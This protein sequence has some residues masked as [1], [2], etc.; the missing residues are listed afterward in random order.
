MA[1]EGDVGLAFGLVIGAGLCTTIGAVLAFFV[2]LNNL[3]LLAGSLGLS[4]GVMLY[5]SFT[6][7]FMAKGLDGFTD[8]GVEEGW[9]LRLATFSFFGGVAVIWVLDML[10]HAIVHCSSKR[11]G[12][13][14][15]CS[16]CNSSG[17][18]GNLRHIGSTKDSV[19]DI[20]EVAEASKKAEDIEA[21]CRNEGGC[22][23]KD[24]GCANKNTCCTDAT[25]CHVAH[26]NSS[27][28]VV[29][30]LISND[31]HSTDLQKMGMLTALAIFIHN[32]P[33][34]LAT[35]LAAL[36]SPV[37][38]IAIAFAIAIHNIPEGICVAMPVYY[39]T[40]SRLKGFLWAFFSGLSEPVGG[41]LGY[42]ILYGDNMSDLA[43]GILFT[44]VAGMMVYISIRELIPTALKYDPEDKY[45]TKFVFLGM[46]VMAVSLL[47]FTI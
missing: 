28:P 47:L 15:A 18:E 3:S 36:A 4:A 19:K 20:V 10:V 30:A 14:S 32:L 35:F 21:C 25:A 9:D 7:I 37:S 11:Q 17:E 5:V 31:H 29:D 26:V 16:T 8:A 23:N 22:C 44:M 38:G 34:G 13:A 40:G 27:S 33:E 45:T 42:L 43:Y 2:S 46:V 39:A 41:L 6:E 12:A 24:I 1:A